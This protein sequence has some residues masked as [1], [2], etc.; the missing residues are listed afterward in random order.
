MLCELLFSCNR[1]YWEE[2]WM[3]APA[4]TA[5]VMHTELREV[6]PMMLAPMHDQFHHTTSKR[7]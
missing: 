2:E 4:I 6:T 7:A 1:Y 5:D 3:F